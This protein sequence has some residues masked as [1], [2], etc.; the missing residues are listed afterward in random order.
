V[1]SFVT[2]IEPGQHSHLYSLT[3]LYIVGCLYSIFHPD[4]YLT[5]CQGLQSR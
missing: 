2:S 4:F 1:K 3:M 5:A